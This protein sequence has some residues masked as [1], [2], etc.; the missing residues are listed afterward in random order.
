MWKKREFIRATR[1]VRILPIPSPPETIAEIRRQTQQIGEALAVVGLLNIQFAVA[2]DADGG[3][4]IYVLEV[5]PRASRTVPFLTK[6]TGLP[7]PVWRQ[8]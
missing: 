2:K 6:A 1:L 7:L 8:N 3:D 5:N 4:Q